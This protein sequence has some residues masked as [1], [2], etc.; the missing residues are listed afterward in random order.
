MCHNS[1]YVDFSTI[2]PEEFK[3]KFAYVYKL[4]IM[5]ARLISY[6]VLLGAFYPIVI[7]AAQ[8]LSKNNSALKEGFEF[9][10]PIGSTVCLVLFGLLMKYQKNK[11]RDVKALLVFTAYFT[12]TPLLEPDNE[13]AEPM[14]N[15]IRPNSTGGMECAEPMMNSIRPNSTSG[16]ECAEPMMNDIRPNSTSGMK[17][18]EPMM[19]DIRP[20]STS[21]IECV[22]P[23]VGKKN[24]TKKSLHLNILEFKYLNK[25]FLF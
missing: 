19:N 22:M 24:P 10:I 9:A 15:D 8:Q 12:T 3:E 11:T 25:G 4:H 7:G 1:P 14:M 21:D 16:M 23:P 20:N 5:S 13:C 2:A 6:V 17:C 18:A